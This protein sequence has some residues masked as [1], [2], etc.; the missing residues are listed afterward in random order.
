MTARRSSPELRSPKHVSPS[1]RA[2]LVTFVA[3]RVPRRDTPKCK[4]PSYPV[5]FLSGLILP[6]TRLGFLCQ[7]L[8]LRRLGMFRLAFA[9]IR[10]NAA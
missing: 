5:T 9:R 7:S 4:L 3:I 8:L 1:L 6:Q 2:D 10:R